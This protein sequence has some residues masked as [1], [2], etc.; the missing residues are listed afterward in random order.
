VKWVEEYAQNDDNKKPLFLCE[1]CHAMG[2]GPGDLK[3]YWD[4]I[5]KY[6]KLMG[7]CVWEWC[8]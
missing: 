2:N 4:V 3:D 5:Y 6:P 8:D 7:A 1:Y